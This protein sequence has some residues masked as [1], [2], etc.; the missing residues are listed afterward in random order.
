[1]KQD[2]W[3]K[4]LHTRV[5]TFSQSCVSFSPA[6]LPSS[7]ACLTLVPCSPVAPSPARTGPCPSPRTP[8]R[9]GT[10][11]CAPWRPWWAGW[12]GWGRTPCC[13]PGRSGCRGR[14]TWRRPGSSCTRWGRCWGTRSA[15]GPA[16]RRYNKARKQKGWI[17][18]SIYNLQQIK[19]GSASFRIS[20]RR[21]LLVK[22]EIYVVILYYI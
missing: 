7:S 3:L 21:M 4:P 18:T 11:F 5:T 15:A 12:S 8:P 22:T 20:Y 1:M 14:W 17:W 13:S 16:T 2:M 10:P 6:I 9:T 19:T